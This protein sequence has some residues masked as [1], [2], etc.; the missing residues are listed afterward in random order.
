MAIVAGRIDRDDV[1]VGRIGR[2]ATGKAKHERE[3]GQA[4]ES[5]RHWSP[6]IEKAAPPALSP[7]ADR[8]SSG[9]AHAQQ[10]DT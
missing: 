6:L 2:H 3:R 7:I 5:S 9:K 1:R 4:F 10:R 8:E